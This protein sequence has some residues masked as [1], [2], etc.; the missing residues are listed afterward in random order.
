VQQPP[1]V[2][3][4]LDVGEPASS[5]WRASAVDVG[6][7]D[8]VSFSFA[9]VSVDADPL[10]AGTMCRARRASL[11][12]GLKGEREGASGRVQ[13][14]H[15]RA[16]RGT[17]RRSGATTNDALTLETASPVLWAWRT[18]SLPMTATSGSRLERQDRTAFLAV[19]HFLPRRSSADFSCAGVGGWCSDDTGRGWAIGEGGTSW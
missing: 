15:V 10:R 12:R 4:S 1:A 18:A 5:P 8:R 3:P 17:N 19:R 13:T 16:Q 2:V 9:G 6:L 7:V 11:G 14:W